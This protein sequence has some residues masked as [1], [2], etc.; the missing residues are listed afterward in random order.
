[1]L[2]LTGTCGTHAPYMRPVYPSKTFPNLYSLAT[3]FLLIACFCRQYTEKKS[4]Q[5]QWLN[6]NN[7]SLNGSQGL[8][9]ESHGI[10]GNSMHDPVFNATF[11]LRSREKLSHR[12]W[13]G[14]PVSTATLRK[15]T[16]I[17]INLYVSSS[18]NCS[19]CF[20]HL[21]F[22]NTMTVYLLVSCFFWF[23]FC[24]YNW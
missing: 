16:T 19:L 10:V 12:W 4:N 5:V 9:P 14:Q 7:P 22:I 3:V 1:M 13:G 11:T 23:S 20:Y 17:R 6:C 21:Q 2:I 24:F 18:R 8:Y 15:I